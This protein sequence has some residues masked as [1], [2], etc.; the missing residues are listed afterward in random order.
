MKKKWIILIS[1]LLLVFAAVVWFNTGSEPAIIVKGNLSAK[2]VAEIK[3]IA[4]H[5]LRH[6]IFPEFSWKNVKTLP[7]KIKDYSHFKLYSIQPA[8]KGFISVCVLKHFSSVETFERV[9]EFTN[10]IANGWHLVDSYEMM[11]PDQSFGD[12]TM[13]YLH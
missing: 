4:R 3:R 8:G 12:P 11:V 9:Y 13:I 2:D 5:K 7:D 6:D 1:T 10:N